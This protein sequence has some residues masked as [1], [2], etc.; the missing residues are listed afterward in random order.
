M[1]RAR[2]AR[3]ERRHRGRPRAPADLQR[4]QLAHDAGRAGYQLLYRAL[5]PFLLGALVFELTAPS[6]PLVWPG[7]ALS[8]ALAVVVSFGVRF[9]VN[10][11]AFW[12][13]DYAA[14]CCWP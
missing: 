11:L 12:L 4:A 5:P 13:T 7:F 6:D 9:V 1:D 10:L 3:P 14:R 2:A 8:V